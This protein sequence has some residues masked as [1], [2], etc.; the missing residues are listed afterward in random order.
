MKAV[1]GW[2]GMGK[3]LHRCESGRC[4][5]EYFVHIRSNI[6]LLNM[7]VKGALLKQLMVQVLA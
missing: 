3:D 6:H 4:L 1:A 5:L 7:G 2:P